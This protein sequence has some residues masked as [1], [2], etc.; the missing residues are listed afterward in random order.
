MAGLDHVQGDHHSF[1]QKCWLDETAIAATYKRMMS[2]PSTMALPIYNPSHH[3]CCCAKERICSNFS[4]TA[5]A[6]VR[7]SRRVLSWP[8]LG[9]VRF[10]IFPTTKD[11][12]S[13]GLPIW[14]EG[15]ASAFGLSSRTFSDLNVQVYKT[16]VHCKMM[17]LQFPFPQ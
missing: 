5:I 17:R 6:D 12:E 14:K 4:P 8:C 13:G 16:A 2:F 7:R 1:L 15:S 10:S 11:A 3:N 9:F